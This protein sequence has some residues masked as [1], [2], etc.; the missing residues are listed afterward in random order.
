MSAD[1]YYYNHVAS[2]AK[3]YKAK[4]DVNNINRRKNPLLQ[5]NKY[6]TYNSDKYR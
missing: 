4:K 5:I 3:I 1:L 2:T 6:R